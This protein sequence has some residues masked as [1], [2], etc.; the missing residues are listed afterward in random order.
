MRNLKWHLYRFYKAAYPAALR[1]KKRVA[2]TG[3]LVF[4]AIIASA[5]VGCD[6]TRAA[7]YQ[8]F[9][10]LC[11]LYL[12][13]LLASC[14]FRG[15]FTVTRKLPAYATAGEPL[16][17]AILIHNHS[18]KRRDHLLLQEVPDIRFP[19][20]EDF[21]HAREPAEL[22]RNSW[23]RMMLY[24]RF[25]W[26]MLQLNNA[27]PKEQKIPTIAA[28]SYLKT[29]A[30]LE[31]RHRGYI[32]LSGLAIKRLEPLGLFKSTLRIPAR[33][34]LLVLPKRYPIPHIELPGTRKFHA[35]GIT[36]ASSVA[37]A[38]EF[39]ALREYRPG[40]PMRM[41]HW[42]SIAKTGELI[43]REHEDE[44]FVRHALVLDTF[45]T[46]AFNARF[47]TAVS[48][49]AS[50][51]STIR[52]QES[53]LD[54]MFVGD[55]SHCFSSGRGVDHTRKM[56]EIL[57]GIE[58]CTDKPFAD[59][60]PLVRNHLSLLSGCICILQRWDEEREALVRMLMQNSVPAKVIVMVQGDETLPET[61][62]PLHA[63]DID[64]PEEGLR[65]L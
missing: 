25:E 59:L 5:V 65:S 43:I 8:M 44:Y 45:A 47:E 13:A 33:D 12:L 14:F 6:T 41:L 28:N 15:E 35:G 3:N 21:M 10:I 27:I 48:I 54:L 4:F 22:K 7:V 36:L 38:D 16:K 31:P 20:F 2:P 53:M 50:F 63:V 52:T 19:S 37:N 29:F 40:D 56:L 64:H 58:A 49:A 23:D 17:Y 61:F 55:R 39:R 1:R 62:V 18:K 24:Y 9:T 34:R 30:E 46:H 32:E 42:K 11:A 51:A 60:Y 26:L 57:A